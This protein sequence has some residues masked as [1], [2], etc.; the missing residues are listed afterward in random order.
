MNKYFLPFVGPLFGI[1]SACMFLALVEFDWSIYFLGA[2]YFL[3]SLVFSISEW[4]NVFVSFY[5]TV[6][7]T[8]LILSLINKGNKRHYIIIL[9]TIFLLHLALT[10][11]GGMD[12]A[13][14]LTESIKN[15]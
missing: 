4:N 8:A 6:L 5:Y 12:F 7:W 2:P 1:I 3:N 10:Y 14:G 9:S 15:N 11:L 13:Q